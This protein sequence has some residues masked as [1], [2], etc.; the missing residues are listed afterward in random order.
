MN[1][2]IYHYY[3]S[4]GLII[5]II[6]IAVGRNQGFNLN[7]L[8]QLSPIGTQLSHNSPQILPQRIVPQHAPRAPT[9][10][11]LYSSHILC[12]AAIGNKTPRTPVWLFRQAGRHLPE[13]TSYKETTGLNFLG[14]L[15]DPKHIAECTMQPVRRY[16]VDAAILFSD[17]LVVP[18]A[19]GVEVTMPG[20]VGIQVP[21]PITS[22]EMAEETIERAKDP[23]AV[24]SSELSYVMEGVKMIKESLSKEGKSHVPLIGFSAAPWTLFYYM[25]GGTSK[26]N[27]EVG[28]EWVRD[29]PEL[30]RRLMDSLAD[31]V[32]E[33]TSKQ[34]EVRER[35]RERGG[36][37]LWKGTTK[38]TPQT[39]TELKLYIFI[40]RG[41]TSTI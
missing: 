40:Y 6:N 13:Y 19:L 20:G 10:T 26:K 33:Y 1:T 28:M 24:V 32:I 8:T 34:I 9:P 31:M 22:P 25:L 2:S 16:E 30:S 29:R 23:K 3:A 37:L 4:I 39:S 5:L 12:D 38:Y 35:E 41:F 36:T 15:A 27:Q 14:L 7:S 17:I 21:Q 18:Q 11:T